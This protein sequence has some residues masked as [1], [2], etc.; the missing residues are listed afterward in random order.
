MQRAAWRSRG[1]V[2]AAISAVCL[3]LVMSAPAL[4]APSS[5]TD[6]FIGTAL[7]PA[8]Q[9]SPVSVDSGNITVRADGAIGIGYSYN[10]TGHASG[11]LPGAFAYE[12]HGFLF[13]RDPADPTSMVGSK[14]SSGVFRL[15]PTRGGGTITIAD[16]APEHYSSGVQT[17]LAKLPPQVHSVLGGSTASVGLTYGYFTFTN[18]YGTFTGY[19]T[20]DFARFAIQISF[21][22][23]QPSR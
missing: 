21:A 12:E 8:G 7:I 22:S 15:T 14:F 1:A 2:L 17:A 11:Q 5:V 10:A 3:L 23:P 18:P 20:P 9:T 16:T 13:F 19:A 4:A 6:S